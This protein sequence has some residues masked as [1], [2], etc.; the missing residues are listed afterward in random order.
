MNSL[1]ISSSISGKII[2]KSLGF[3]GVT[4]SPR[5]GGVFFL[6]S[7]LYSEREF[8]IGTVY[9]VFREHL[10]HHLNS[11]LRDIVYSLLRDWYEKLEMFGNNLISSKMWHFL[12]ISFLYSER[13]V[14]IFA[15]YAVLRDH[16]M[17]HFQKFITELQ[18]VPK[19]SMEV[20][21]DCTMA[22][23]LHCFV[24]HQ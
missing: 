4:Q 21:F 24:V 12:L 19:V 23:S 8:L 6:I 15:V 22:F 7:F 20:I 9:A 1:V 3:S 18:S 10:I 16:L 13:E 5:K 14:L 2:K 11:L 17:Y